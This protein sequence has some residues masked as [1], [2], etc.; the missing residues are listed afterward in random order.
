[1]QFTYQVDAESNEKTVKSI[2]KNKFKFS[3][4]LV[5]KCKYHG[6]VLC[7]GIP[8]Y[9]NHRV[10]TGDVVEVRIDFQETSENVKPVPMDLR[11]LYEDD[12]LIALDK[13]PGIIIHPIGGNTENTIANGLMYYFNS[14]GHQLKIRPVSR[15][16]RDTTGVIVFAKNGYIHEKLIH[17]MKSNQYKK[18][19]I[20]IVHGCPA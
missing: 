4:N 17:Q 14:K 8:V 9:M 10:R 3:E 11:I 5:K 2:L 12:S 18:N 20:G 15:L 13:P 16:D 1:M 7:N 6:E 19:Y